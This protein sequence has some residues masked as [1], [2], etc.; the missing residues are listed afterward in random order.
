[1]PNVQFFQE[2]SVNLECGRGVP[3]TGLSLDMERFVRERGEKGLETEIIGSG[4]NVSLVP[5]SENK[6]IRLIHT[7]Y[8]IY[9]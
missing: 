5:D 3:L 2:E 6:N 4:Y 9:K 8:I 1:M 7:F